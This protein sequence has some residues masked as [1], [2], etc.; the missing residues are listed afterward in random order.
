MQITDKKG[1]DIRIENTYLFIMNL[2]LKTL[3]PD[4]GDSKA[5]A[6]DRYVYNKKTSFSVLPILYTV[7][8]LH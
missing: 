6:T 1:I 4:P 3:G 2:S 8:S 5:L 7:K